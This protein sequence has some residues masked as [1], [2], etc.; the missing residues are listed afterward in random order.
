LL[1]TV[2]NRRLTASVVA[3]TGFVTVNRALGLLAGV[4]AAQIVVSDCVGLAAVLALGAVVFFRWAA[5]GAAV[6]LAG[7]A[8]A[9]ARPELAVA[10]FSAAT[11]LGL[12]LG[13]AFVARIART[14]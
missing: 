13:V 3:L 12:L 14:R 10:A 11:G 5:W 6:L 4:G 2:L 8:V 9:A 7:A 1:R